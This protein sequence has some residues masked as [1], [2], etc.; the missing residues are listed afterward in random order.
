MS[1]RGHASKTGGGLL[2]LGRCF[3][4]DVPCS[5]ACALFLTIVRVHVPHM[6]W[7]PVNSLLSLLPLRTLYVTYVHVAV[8]LIMSYENISFS[9]ICEE[10]HAALLEGVLQEVSA[11]AVVDNINRLAADPEARGD[12]LP[13]LT[14][15]QLR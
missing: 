15:P 2:G 7:A 3:L 9:R 8:F 11:L 13:Q 14:R 1:G 6:D 4:S 10:M 12:V 5:V